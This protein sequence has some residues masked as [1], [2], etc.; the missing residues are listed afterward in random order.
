VSKAAFAKA[1]QDL[2]PAVK[3]ED[4]VSWGCGLR[5]QALDRRGELL[6]DFVIAQGEEALFVLNAP[7]PAATAALAIGG[8]LAQ[9]VG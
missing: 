5:A 9:K 7:S 2:V 3:K 8:F 1:L 6:D 4:L